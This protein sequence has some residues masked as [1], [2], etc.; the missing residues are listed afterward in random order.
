LRLLLTDLGAEGW[1][2]LTASMQDTRE[3]LSVAA[4]FLPGAAG[5]V[6][7]LRRVVADFAS[8]AVHTMAPRTALPVERAC[9]LH[10]V[11]QRS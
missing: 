10:S 8:F 5:E 6:G 1:H 4:L 3:Q 11:R 9:G 7:Y 2:R